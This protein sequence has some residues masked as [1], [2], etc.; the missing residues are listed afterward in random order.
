MQL[1][2]R[3]PQVGIPIHSEISLLQG[4]GCCASWW[5][6]TGPLCEQKKE[7]VEAALK[8]DEDAVSKFELAILAVGCVVAVV[9]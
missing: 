1:T 2:V 9:A 7:E 6:L 4:L 8:A 3:P 5:A